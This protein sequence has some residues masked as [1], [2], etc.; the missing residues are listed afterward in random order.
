MTWIYALILAV[1]FFP[2]Q[3]PAQVLFDPQ[4]IRFGVGFEVDL[5]TGVIGAELPRYSDDS[6]W[7]SRR[8]SQPPE[9]CFAPPGITAI[10]AVPVLPDEIFSF[11]ELI[12]INEQPNVSFHCGEATFVTVPFIER[13]R[14]DGTWTIFN[15]APAELLNRITHARVSALFGD[16]T[17]DGGATDGEVREVHDDGI[18][19]AYRLLEFNDRAGAVFKEQI[20]FITNGEYELAMFTESPRVLY[21]VGIQGGR[22]T[23]VFLP[24]VDVETHLF[25]LDMLSL[26]LPFSSEFDFEGDRAV[27]PL[28]LQAHFAVP[29]RFLSDLENTIEIF[30][31]SRAIFYE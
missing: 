1:I 5:E 31:K 20:A 14:F 8:V 22:H 24:P 15:S 29:E 28:F 18:K 6:G 11:I 17:Y 27:G 10:N 12:V 7:P 21:V 19:V 16:E 2:V 23:I 25:E 26:E 4:D 30:R 9:D 13:W 3:V